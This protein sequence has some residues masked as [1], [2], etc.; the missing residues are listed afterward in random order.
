MSSILVLNICHYLKMFEM[1]DK[2]LTNPIQM[3]VMPIM[4]KLD[5]CDLNYL[6]KDHPKTRYH[7]N[8]TRPSPL[9]S[10]LKALQSSK[11]LDLLPC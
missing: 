7:I 1:L 2:L 5:S 9:E 4:E 8:K 11:N 6:K 10:H 3:M